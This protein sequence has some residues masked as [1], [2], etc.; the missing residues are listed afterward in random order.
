MLLRRLNPSFQRRLAAG[1]LAL[2]S[3]CAHSQ[4]E[5]PFITTPDRVTL[6]MLKLAEVGPG[7]RLIDLGSGDGRIVITA[8]R[9]YGTRGLGVEI[10]PDLVQRSRESALR[11]G[12]AQRVEFREQDLFTTD[13]S[14]ASV[15]TMYLLPDVNLQ[16]RPRLL[17]LSPGTRIVSH[18]W[19]MGD[20]QADRRLSLDV[21]EKT[22][23][24]EK[25]SQLFL[26]WVPAPVAGLW[27]GPGGRSLRLEQRYQT[28]HGELTHIQ[29]EESVTGRL[30]GKDL[31]L[32]GVR[33]E[34]RLQWQSPGFMRTLAGPQRLPAAASGTAK[35]VRAAA[36][37]QAAAGQ[38]CTGGG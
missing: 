9:L 37:R 26:W 29:G 35:P 21:P 5:V 10:V 17:A 38:T 25:R 8:A 12:V 7:D 1:L 30:A 23:G 11:A 31:T 4:E 15:I 20:W 2:V 32:H 33:S 6:A 13:L 14:A 22:I 27:C 28:V 34:W 18:D 3:V 19:D 36:W 24:R 16:L